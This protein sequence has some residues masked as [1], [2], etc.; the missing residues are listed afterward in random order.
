MLFRLIVVQNEINVS[1]VNM[2]PYSVS[3]VRNKKI[4]SPYRFSFTRFQEV[5][6]CVPCISIHRSVDSYSNLLICNHQDLIFF[7]RS[8]QTKWHNHELWACSDG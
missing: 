8:V 5:I 6:D 2:R 7:L 4:K 1:N 3:L